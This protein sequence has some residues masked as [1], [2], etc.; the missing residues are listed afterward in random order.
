ML[1]SQNSEDFGVVNTIVACS[2]QVWFI[3]RIINWLH[4]SGCPKHDTI[5]T[6]EGRNN[7]RKISPSLH[8][9]YCEKYEYFTSWDKDSWQVA[10]K[11]SLVSV[12]L[13]KLHECNIAIAFPHLLLLIYTTEM[14]GARLFSSLLFWHLYRQKRAPLT[15]Q[16]T[17]A[18]HE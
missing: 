9:A 17:G 4:R 10:H 7:R 8:F 2:N 16:V 18:Y 5:S 11:S 13:P 6:E 3:A 1:L 14:H 15:F 12:S